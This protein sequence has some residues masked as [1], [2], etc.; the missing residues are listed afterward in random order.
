MRH[1]RTPKLPPRGFTL[2]EI[3][4]VIAIIAVLA[5]I[6]FMSI[7]SLNKS[8]N[9]AKDASTLRQIWN[10]IQMY[11][12]DQNDL[13]PG[14]LFTRQSPIYNRPIPTNPR[15]WRRLSDCVAPY[16]G[17]DSSKQGDFIEPMAA[18]WQKTP[19]ARNAP[20]LYMQQKLPIGDG[21]TT[22]NPWGIPAPAS[23]DMRSPMRM[24]TVMSQ[25]L[26]S[27]TWAITEF[28]QLHPEISDPDL[29][30]GTPDGMTHGKFRLGV[31]FDGSVGKL[32]TNN[33]AL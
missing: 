28:D 6:G 23:V 18:S 21:Q 22:R 14:P 15:E 27:R 4:V 20:S 16:L 19:L 9:A 10:G 32:D 11:S 26:A 17:Y 33:K 5:A 2:T 29:K 25:P 31:Y 3:L 24:S 12:G 8:A 1:S 30:K 7:S 13:M